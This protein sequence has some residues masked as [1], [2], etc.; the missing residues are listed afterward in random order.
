MKAATLE[1]EI[2]LEGMLRHMRGSRRQAL[3]A[4]AMLNL[5]ILE[6]LSSG[7]LDTEE[8][9]RRFY[10]VEN[11]LYVR[12]RIRDDVC[13]EIMSRGVQLGDLLD[14]LP[15]AEAQ[16]AFASELETLR[17]LC[18]KLLSSSAQ[19]GGHGRSRR[20]NVSPSG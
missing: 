4:F 17:K 2:S 16:R 12:R 20:S 7:V 14:I 18:L 13:D 11:C 1:R 9:V 19:R 15:I 6:S 3:E 10:N 8:A 5:G